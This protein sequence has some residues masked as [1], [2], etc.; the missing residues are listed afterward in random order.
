MVTGDL[1]EPAASTA[2]ADGGWIILPALAG[3]AIPHLLQLQLAVA[4]RSQLAANAAR[5]LESTLRPQ[6]PNRRQVDLLE[7]GV[8]GA[9]FTVNLKPD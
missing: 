3:E 6:A 1:S 2:P 8:E 7:Q 5:V 9:L 4:R